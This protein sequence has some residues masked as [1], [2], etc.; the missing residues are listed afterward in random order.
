MTSSEPGYG[1]TSWALGRGVADLVLCGVCEEGW[2]VRAG[3]V[4]V[5]VAPGEAVVRV[6]NVR[7]VAH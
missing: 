1:Y 3:T 6:D 2:V 5:R 4:E 7:V